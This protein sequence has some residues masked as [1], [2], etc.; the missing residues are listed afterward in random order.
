MNNN[1]SSNS[2]L[3]TS[4]IQYHD[5]STTPTKM[6]PNVLSSSTS[7]APETIDDNLCDIQVYEENELDECMITEVRNNN[8]PSVIT[9]PAL[10]HKKSSITS[11]QGKRKLSNLKY[12]NQKIGSSS[13]RCFFCM[14]AQ[15]HEKNMENIVRKCLLIL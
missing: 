10:K 12:T 6:S 3:N 13:S 7:K 11:I 5:K 1:K 8:L 2:N 9:P 14:D 4:R 15:C